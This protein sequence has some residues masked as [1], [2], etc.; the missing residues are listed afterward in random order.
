MKKIKHIFESSKTGQAG[1]EGRGKFEHF[2]SARESMGVHDSLRPNES[3]SGREF[4]PFERTREST[5]ELFCHA[6]A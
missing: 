5:G 2:T 1:N 6:I 4:K 3:E